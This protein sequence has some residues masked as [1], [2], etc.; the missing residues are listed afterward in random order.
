MRQKLFNGDRALVG[1]DRGK[2]FGQGVAPFQRALLLQSKNQ[3]R[4]ERLRDGSN[5]ISRV[6]VKWLPGFAETLVENEMTLFLGEN[7]AVKSK[8]ASRLLDFRFPTGSFL[9]A[10]THPG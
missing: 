5:P 3:C 6:T 2:E 1:R 8:L 9:R 7:D 4:G 10:S